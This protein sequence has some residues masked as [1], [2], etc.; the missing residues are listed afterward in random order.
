MTDQ[1]A[2]QQYSSNDSKD[3]FG[4]EE[5]QQP[6]NKQLKMDQDDNEG[7]E[8]QFADS[9]FAVHNFNSQFGAFNENPTGFPNVGVKYDGEQPSPLRNGHEVEGFKQSG[10]PVA[11]PQRGYQSAVYPTSGYPQNPGFRMPSDGA[12]SVTQQTAPY[13]SG[14][15]GESGYGFNPLQNQ[16][17][18]NIPENETQPYA[19]GRESGFGDYNAENEDDFDESGGE[20]DESHE[21]DEGLLGDDEVAD[22]DGFGDEEDL[23]EEESVEDNSGPIDELDSWKVI[24]AFFRTHGLVHQQLESFNDFI[25]FKMQEIVSNHPPIQLTA[26]SHMTDNSGDIHLVYRLKF[27]QLT[28]S[29]PSTE[30]KEGESRPIWPLEARLRNLTYAAP[31]YVEIVQETYQVHGDGQ[32][33]L[34]DSHKYESVHLGRVPMMLRSKYCWLYGLKDKG[35]SSMGECSFDQGG[36]FIINGMEKVLIAQ[37]K[38]ASNFVYVFKKSPPAKYSWMAEIR[39]QRE[40]MQATSPF[41][42]KLKTRVQGSSSTRS[43]AFGQIVATLPYIRTEV[44]IVI[45]FRALGVL[46]DRDVCQRIVY[47]MKDKQMLNLLRPS[48]EEGGPFLTQNVCLD[49]IGRRGPTVGAPRDLRIRYAKELLHKEVLAHVGFEEGCEHSKAWFVGYMVHRLLLGKNIRLSVWN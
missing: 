37:E 30:E 6:S 13:G 8:S 36:Y 43:K 41:S 49:F 7:S 31:V 44:P 16:Q 19:M 18:S 25:T 29:R 28:I 45:L 2:T 40:G 17:G 14:Y 46:S 15:S 21:Q 1:W 32:E 48:L 9:T 33:K 23:L 39:S 38:M 11:S 3:V 26:P 47:D 42:I 20:F 34:V 12:Y 4:D 10:F 24:S 22:G 5:A 35:I 27:G